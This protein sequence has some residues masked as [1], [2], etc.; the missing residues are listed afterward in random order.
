MAT[1]I[2]GLS[3][4]LLIHPGETLSEVLEDR[5][6]NQNELALVAQFEKKRLS[7]LHFLI[8]LSKLKRLRK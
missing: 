2:T 7:N 5:N 6:M 3:P 1:K 8:F 4:E